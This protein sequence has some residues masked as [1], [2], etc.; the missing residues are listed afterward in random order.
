MRGAT[1]GG[2]SSLTNTII[3]VRA[4]APAAARPAN[5]RTN[6]GVR[7][8]SAVPRLVTHKVHPVAQGREL[9]APVRVQ[10]EIPA[11]VREAAHAEA[12]IEV[13]L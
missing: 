11:A 10:R 5:P 2:K 13:S 1:S 7:A 3:G 12:S 6:P 8:V 9:L 4:E